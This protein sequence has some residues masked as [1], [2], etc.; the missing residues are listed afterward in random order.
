MINF[1]ACAEYSQSSSTKDLHLK[2]DKPLASGMD[3]GVRWRLY[4]NVD[5]L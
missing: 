4:L 1:L 2:T 3:V 5:D